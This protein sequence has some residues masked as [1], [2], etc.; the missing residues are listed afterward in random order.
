MICRFGHWE[1][2][3]RPWGMSHKEDACSKFN[4][5]G[6]EDAT[7]R[8]YLKSGWYMHNVEFFNQLSPKE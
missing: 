7:D 5:P 6:F 8:S 4:I 3:F 2:R 1:P